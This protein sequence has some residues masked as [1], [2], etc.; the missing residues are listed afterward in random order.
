M[1]SF[2][3]KKLI[4]NISFLRVQQ[5]VPL[6][7]SALEALSYQSSKKRSHSVDEESQSP[8]ATKKPKLTAAQ[9][10]LGKTNIKGI[11]KISSFFDKKTWILKK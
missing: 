8:K 11:S 5:F 9:S 2:N 4:L 3:F 1:K 10:K 7:L 6:K